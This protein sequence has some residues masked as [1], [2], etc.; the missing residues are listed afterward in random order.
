M[1]NEQWNNFMHNIDNLYNC[2]N[3]PENIGMC[4]RR[5]FTECGYDECMV[6]T[7]CAELENSDSKSD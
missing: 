6:K 3:C 4:E 2:D 1:P 5:S 7:C